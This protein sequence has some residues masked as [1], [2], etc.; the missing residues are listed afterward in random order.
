V[1]KGFEILRTF[2]PR[3]TMSI[4]TRALRSSWRVFALARARRRRPSRP[5]SASAKLRRFSLWLRRHR[6]DLRRDVELVHMPR[7]GLGCRLKPTAPRPL[8]C[9]TTLFKARCSR[10]PR[11]YDV[12]GRTCV[13]T[14][15]QADATHVSHMLTK[16]RSSAAAVSRLGPAVGTRYA[17]R[18]C[19]FI[20]SARCRERDGVPSSAAPG[21]N[22][23]GTR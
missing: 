20:L 4:L 11:H 3:S 16:R 2:F 23:C 15:A 7:K 1:G 5:A 6:F 9:G 17:F 22:R 8:P 18:C 21:A 10:C 19:R 14:G 13:G 12:S